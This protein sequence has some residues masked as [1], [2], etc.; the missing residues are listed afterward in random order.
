M[1][2]APAHGSA[3]EEAPSAAGGIQVISRAADILRAVAREPGGMSQ[4]ELAENLGLARTTVH[5][6]VS[7]LEAEG[8]LRQPHTG[9]RYR[10]GGEIARMAAPW[11]RVSWSSPLP[12][13]QGLTASL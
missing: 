11:S 2:R 8:F 7:A 6:I 5:R 12:V 13:A 3:A 1:T 9:A 10:V 4:A